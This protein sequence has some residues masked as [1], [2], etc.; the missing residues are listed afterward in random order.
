MS[1]APSTTYSFQQFYV[2]TPLEYTKTKTMKTT[3]LF[4]PFHLFT[5]RA[6]IT[7]FLALVVVKSNLEHHGA[8]KAHPHHCLMFSSNKRCP[9]MP[10]DF[11][12]F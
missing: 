9:C 8:S 7:M 5:P 4:F 2:P 1:I 3:T 6:T 10:S 12:E 11:T